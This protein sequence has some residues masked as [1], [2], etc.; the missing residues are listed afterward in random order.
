MKAISEIEVPRQ[1]SRLAI[2]Y[3]YVDGS[4]FCRNL[5]KPCRSVST[6]YSIL[7]QSFLKL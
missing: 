3:I 6:A 4:F 1:A 5:H 2:I 7:F